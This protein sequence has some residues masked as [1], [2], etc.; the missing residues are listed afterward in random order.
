MDGLESGGTVLEDKELSP[1]P[2]ISLLLSSKRDNMSESIKS[3]HIGNNLFFKEELFFLAGRDLPIV[4]PSEKLKKN[5]K[6]P[7]RKWKRVVEMESE[8][9]DISTEK[10][11]GIGHPVLC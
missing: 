7:C 4:I 8:G 11:W 2:L 9:A 1:L 10:L 3:Y 6:Q 5:E